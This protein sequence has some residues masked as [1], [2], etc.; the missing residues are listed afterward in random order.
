MRLHGLFIAGLLAG[1]ITPVSSGNVGA[2]A[3]TPATAL[4]QDGDA[5]AAED[6]PEEGAQEGEGAA[7]DGG[8]EDGSAAASDGEAAAPLSLGKEPLTAAE[9]D[10]AIAEFNDGESEP[11][12][13]TDQ[14]RE[15]ISW[16][17]DPAQV[18]NAHLGYAY[19]PTGDDNVVMYERNGVLRT[20]ESGAK[21]QSPPAA[22]EVFTPF[23]RSVD[24][25]S[26]WTPVAASEVAVEVD[27]MFNFIMWTC[28]IFTALIGVLMV[29]FVIKYRRKP[30]VR[31][32]Q[33]ITHNT[34][35][36]I[37]W[38]VVPTILVA[39]MFWGGY[40][41]F[42]DMRTP[43]PGS[44]S[45]EITARAYQWGWEYTYPNGA[46]VPNE[47]HVP[48]NTPVKMTMYST[49][50]IHSFHFPAFRVKS[51]ILPNRYTNVWFDSGGPG[52][53]PVY[54][55]EYCGRNHANMY[56][57]VVVEPQEDFEVWLKEASQ[58]WLDKN[59]EMLPEVE[60]GE[61]GYKKRGCNAC[62]SIDGS[63]IIGPTFAGLWGRERRFN[64]GLSVDAET[65]DAA[66][67]NY[68]RRSILEP[69]SQI[70]Q[71]YTAQMSDYSGMP[72]VQLKG[73]VEYIKSLKDVPRADKDAWE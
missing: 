66:D 61:L 68:I 24:E 30:G 1:L 29:V 25:G 63:E 64:P 49:D 44:N 70:V 13:F 47:F 11:K 57:K 37:F 18:E 39:I 41:T 62:H 7:D 21:F 26:F 2:A 67:A 19:I 40:T 33:S 38:S 22:S 27:A 56:T 45:L 28:Y 36:E 59:G 54:C 58:W 31:A 34:P 12:S 48:E 69:H 60:V 5:P 9:I 17:L 43:P 71:G 51:D 4:F 15:W 35:L 6:E 10:E 55:S 42:L 46:V 50:V 53:Y 65:V 8:S 73:F 72:E 16:G 23:M 14:E 3:A 20:I 32:D 52:M